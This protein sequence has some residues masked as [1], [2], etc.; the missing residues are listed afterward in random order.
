MHVDLKETKI[1][2]LY[3]TWKFLCCMAVSWNG[4]MYPAWTHDLVVCDAIYFVFY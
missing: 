1:K 3:C 2:C 4:E